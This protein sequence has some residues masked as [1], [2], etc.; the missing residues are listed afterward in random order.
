M[1]EITKNSQKELRDAWPNNVCY[2]GS[3]F[4]DG[5]Y[6]A[7]DFAEKYIFNDSTRYQEVYVGYVPS[8]D[9]FVVGW[10]TWLC[11]EDTIKTE[12]YAT[13]AVVEFDGRKIKINQKFDCDRFYPFGLKRIHDTFPDVKDLR[14]D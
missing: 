6:N 13:I 8:I 14:L 7:L 3:D 10:D 4:F 1:K 11:N 2:K 12:M 5:F 9:Q